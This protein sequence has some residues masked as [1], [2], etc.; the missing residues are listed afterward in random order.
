MN[1]GS[2]PY[3]N[4]TTIHSKRS[5][6]IKRSREE[7]LSRVLEAEAK[8]DPARFA[9]LACRPDD[10]NV[11]YFEGVLRGVTDGGLELA[12]AHELCVR[13]HALP[14]RP[15][16]R[17]LVRVIENLAELPLPDELLQMLSFY[18][19]EDPDP[20]Q[21][22]W[23]TPAG[24]GQVYFGGSIDMA[25]LNLTRGAA[26]LAVGSVINSDRARI[27]VMLPTLEQLVR[28]SSITVR[29]AVARALL[30]VMRHDR[31]TAIRLF[32]A[33]CET[34]DSLL[35]TEGVALFLKAN[36]ATDY[37]ALEAII[38]RMI[39]AADE[40]TNKAGAWLACIAALFNSEAQTLAKTCLSASEAHRKGAAQVYAANLGQ[41]RF[42][43]YCEAQLLTLFNDPS[44]EVRREA[45]R[46][47]SRLKKRFPIMP[48]SLILS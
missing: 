29:A 32:N 1:N 42:R 4:T 7:R 6:A 38:T 41:A 2:A 47:F 43:E 39:T 24:G 11:N 18:A 26:A 33:L 12:T 10:A 25:A 44:P 31:P 20:D 3:P 9:A 15:V 28:D 46:C 48:R 21:E 19:T 5:L 23:R 16:G 27:D 13:C 34:E 40:D 30:G 17:W 22:L 45:A 35:R 8:K 37:P 14:G 36:V